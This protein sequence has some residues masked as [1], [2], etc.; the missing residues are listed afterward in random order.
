VAASPCGL[1]ML[2]NTAKEV[3][4]TDVARSPAL[5]TAEP[6]PGGFATADPWGTQVRFVL[7]P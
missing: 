3:R 2:R 5:W 4:S 6:I 7:A 1:P